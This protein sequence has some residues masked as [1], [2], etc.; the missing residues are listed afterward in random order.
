MHEIILSRLDQA[1]QTILDLII[2]TRGQDLDGQGQRPDVSL[3]CMRTAHT[4]DLSPCVEVF[5]LFRKDELAGVAVDAI[6]IVDELQIGQTEQ[7]GQIGVII[8]SITAQPI[9]LIR[10]DLHPTLHDYSMLIYT[11]SN[12]IGMSQHTLRELPTPRTKD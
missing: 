5:V 4:I 2:R 11:F 8:Q 9:H 3:A 1:S 7:T 10:E 6:V 12:P